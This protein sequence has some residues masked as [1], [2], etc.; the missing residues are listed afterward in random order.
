MA[1]LINISKSNKKSTNK[2]I[3]KRTQQNQWIKVKT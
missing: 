2:K 1:R 3:E